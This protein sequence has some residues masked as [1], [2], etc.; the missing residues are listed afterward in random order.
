MVCIKM[1]NL[2]YM[3]KQRKNHK[4]KEDYGNFCAMVE[5]LPYAKELIL[6]IE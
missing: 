4:L 6:G 2:K 3:Y 5:S 1:N